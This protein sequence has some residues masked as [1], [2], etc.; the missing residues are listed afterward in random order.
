MNTTVKQ[1]K[2]TESCVLLIIVNS[3]FARVRYLSE[4]VT[5]GICT[6]SCENKRAID[7]LFD[8]LKQPMHRY[9]SVLLRPKVHYSRNQMISALRL[10]T[11]Y[12]SRTLSSVLA[13]TYTA[14]ST[15][16]TEQ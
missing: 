3:N 7:I 2:I 8:S 14:M 12:I 9:A 13:E 15:S 6:T 4:V 1:L 16:G 10:T 5:E 11:L